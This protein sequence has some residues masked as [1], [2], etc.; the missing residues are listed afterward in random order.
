MTLGIIGAGP[1]GSFLGAKIGWDK[2]II[3]DGK[4]KIGSPIQ[5]TGI[6]TDSIYRV[7]D[8]IP[9]NVI[10]N[11]I[12][13][14]RIF[15]PDGKSIDVDL[16]KENII[17]HRGKFDQHIAKLA[18]DNGTP[19]KLNHQLK[20]WKKKNNKYRLLFTNG[21]HHDVDYLVGADGP[22]SIV[23]KKANM[24]GE[25]EILPGIQARVR[26]KKQSQKFDKNVTQILFGL[27]EFSWIVPESSTIARIGIIGKNTK[28]FNLKKAFDNLAEPY[29]HLEYQSGQIPMYNPKQKLQQDNI[30]L[31]GDAATQVKATT[32]GGITYGMLSATYLGDQWEGYEKKFNSKLGKDLWISLKMREVL[33]KFSEKECDELLEIFRKEGNKEILEKMDRNFPSKFILK[34]LMKET[35]LWKYGFKLFRK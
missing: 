7:I 33:N 20:G 10:V 21:K 31:I 14:F 22:H 30:A 15:A 2:S 26:I 17:L 11:H 29:K 3:F 5:C 24:Y 16:D 4:P 23:A 35:K 19:I 27:G 13:T 9:D 32:Y 25:R 6:I 12:D 34:L 8:E 1:A 28:H 18:K